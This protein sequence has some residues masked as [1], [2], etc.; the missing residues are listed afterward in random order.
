MKSEGYTVETYDA[1][2]SSTIVLVNG[3]YEIKIH[4]IS[5]LPA[6][7]SDKVVTFADDLKDVNIVVEVAHGQD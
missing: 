3:A 6:F 7:I 2:R 5:D 4:M 1:T